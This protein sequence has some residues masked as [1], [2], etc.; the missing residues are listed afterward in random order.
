MARFNL[1]TD[2]DKQPNRVKK[3]GPN[4]ANVTSKYTEVSKFSRSSETLSA[5][6]LVYNV[7]GNKGIHCS[8]GGNKKESGEFA[9]F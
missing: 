2:L 4:V 8:Q 7:T 5:T 3:K 1:S 9:S 6:N